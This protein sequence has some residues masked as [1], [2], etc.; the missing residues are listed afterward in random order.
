V[1]DHVTIRVSDREASCRFYELGLS[2][3]G[4][5]LS[6]SGQVYDEWNDFGLAQ[7][8]ATEPPTG[9]LHVAF[10]AASREAVDAFWG[11]LTAAGYRDDGSPRERERYA[12]GYYGGFVLD[13]DGNSA[14]AV[15]KATPMRDDGGVIDHV[16]LRVADAAAS[17]RF[18]GTIA[19]HTGIELHYA[20]EDI[21]GFRGF[22]PTY[23]FLVAASEPSGNVH[24][25]F[26]AAPNEAVDDFHRAALA[27]GYHDNGAPS[28]R[29]AYHSGYYSAYVLDPDGNN[30][31]AVCHNR[32]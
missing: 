25:A 30:V 20:R 28:E 24:L 11:T 4:V 31:E 29:P 14:E 3:L 27:A 21:V 13:P 10:C 22:G 12:P 26:P 1:F 19:P 9:R 15:H 6:H 32:D 16:W 8:S 23:L 7:V 17:R 18:Y 2:S 5:E